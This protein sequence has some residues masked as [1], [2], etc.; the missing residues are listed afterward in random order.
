[1]KFSTRS[2][3]SWFCRRSIL[4]STSTIFLPHS[5]MVSMKPRSDSVNG[6]SVE[7][8]KSTR[9]ERGTKLRVSSS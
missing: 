8:M 1:M 3:S 9:S 2:S 5:R 6:R 7:V 4:L